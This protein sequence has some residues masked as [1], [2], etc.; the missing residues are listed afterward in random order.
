MMSMLFSRSRGGDAQRATPPRLL[1][2]LLAGA[3][4]LSGGALAQGTS[5]PPKATPDPSAPSFSSKI[6]A[7]V[8]E[9]KKIDTVQGTG[10]EASAG[11]AVL[12]HYTGWLYDPSAPSG[13]GTKFD[14]SIDRMVPF[15]FILGAGKV[16]KGWDDGVAGMKVGGKR[17]LVIPP[18]M[19]YGARGAGNVIPPNATLL[20]D[21]ELVDI[22]S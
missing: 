22:R 14:S 12:V 16:I 10:A 20:F 4:A 6:G 19:G 18:D 2:F 11:K 9:L 7:K 3:L 5:A 15:G 8:T 21:V 13:K 17:T 1:T